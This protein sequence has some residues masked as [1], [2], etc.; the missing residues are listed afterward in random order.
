VVRIFRQAAQPTAE[1][2]GDL[3]I[4][5][6]DGNKVWVW[7]GAAWGEAP[8]E[9][10]NATK[11]GEWYNSSGVEIDASIGITMNGEQDLIFNYGSDGHYI[12][13]SSGGVFA[14]Q[15]DKKSLD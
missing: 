13:D 2:T 11:T 9:L 15:N 10:A 7:T 14:F 6:D 1:N 5:S 4:D 8:P 12:Y 3:W